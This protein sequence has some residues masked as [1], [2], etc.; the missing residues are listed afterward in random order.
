VRPIANYDM[1]GY[2]RITVGRER[3]NEKLVQDL[4]EVLST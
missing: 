2:L 4:A 1:P 3:D